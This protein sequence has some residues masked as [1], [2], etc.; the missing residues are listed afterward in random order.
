MGQPELDE[1]LESQNLRQLKQRI[2]LRCRLEPLSEQETRKYV[3]LRLFLAGARERS[4]NI[5]SDSALGLVHSYSNGIPR[6]VNTIC[7][8]A[9]V[10]SFALKY[11]IVTPEIIDEVAV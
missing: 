4:Q 9:L 3:A 2:A 8:T 10:A 7:E 1:K 5:F 11:P 6:L